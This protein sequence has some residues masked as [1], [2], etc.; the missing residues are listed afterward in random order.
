M[1]ALLVNKFYAEK[2]VAWLG[3]VFFISELQY[4]CEDSHSSNSHDI[5]VMILYT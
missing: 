2:I 3:G 1:T 5:Q 4:I